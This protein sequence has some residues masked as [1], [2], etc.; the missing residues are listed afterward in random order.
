MEVDR[1]LEATKE[2]METTQIASPATKEDSRSGNDMVAQYFADTFAT[3][4]NAFDEH[5]GEKLRAHAV[6]ALKYLEVG[7]IVQ[8]R[9][10]AT[11]ALQY[12]EASN[13]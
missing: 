12:M 9:R 6:E 10:Q 7:D 13:T 3:E 1:E 11:A 8:L 2:E 5:T 4:D